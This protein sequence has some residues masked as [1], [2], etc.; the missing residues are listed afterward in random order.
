MYKIEFT[1]HNCIKGPFHVQYPFIAGITL[2]FLI[3]TTL[4]II[5]IVLFAP[6][7]TSAYT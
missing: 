2:M 5:I 6:N 4:F 3:K 1:N 7:E